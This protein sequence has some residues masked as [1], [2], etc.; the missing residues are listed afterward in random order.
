MSYLQIISI[1]NTF[2]ISA[3]ELV[4]PSKRV[5]ANFVVFLSYCMGYMALLL[6]AYFYRD[7]R[8]L[9]WASSVPVGLGHIVLL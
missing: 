5:F 8:E 3:T 6:L 2:V 1:F 9:G 7:W 4:E